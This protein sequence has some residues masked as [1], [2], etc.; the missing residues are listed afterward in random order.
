GRLAQLTHWEDDNIDACAL[1]CLAIRHT[2]RTGELD[3]RSQL[4]WLSADRRDRW[5]ELIDEALAPGAHPRDFQQKNGWVVRAFQ[6]ALA[7]VAEA[8]ATSGRPP[9][10]DALERAVRGGGDTDTVAA[11]TG[12]LA[13]ALWGATQVPLSWRRVLHGWPGLRGD[14]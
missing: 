5:A 3:I 7:A 2:I 13:G 4:E 9:L 11:I 14:D 12:S 1:W 10:V 8:Q 6:G